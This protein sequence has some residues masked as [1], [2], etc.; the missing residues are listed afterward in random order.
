MILDFRTW[1]KKKK[2][3]QNIVALI[4]ILAVVRI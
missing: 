4:N 2:K 3:M 1:K